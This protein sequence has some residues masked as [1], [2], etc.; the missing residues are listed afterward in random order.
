MK[1]LSKLEKIYEKL[2]RSMAYDYLK[3]GCYS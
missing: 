3:V 1:I 2:L